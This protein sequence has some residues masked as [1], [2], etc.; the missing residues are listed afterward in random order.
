MKKAI[1]TILVLTLSVCAL[2]ACSN[3]GDKETP[4][5]TSEISTSAE[6]ASVGETTK[7]K[8]AKLTTRE[9]IEKVQSLSMDKLGLDGKQK[10]YVFMVASETIT[11]DDQEY[12]EVDANVQTSTNKDGTINMTTKGRYLVRVDGKKMLVKDMKTGETKELK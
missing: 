5:N 2:A 4:A 6:N 1:I 10:D 8:D 12:L 3:D 11:I 7:D 9:A